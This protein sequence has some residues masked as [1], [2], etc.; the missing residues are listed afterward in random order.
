MNGSEYMYTV[1]EVGVGLSGFAAIVMV[2]RRREGSSLS[3]LDRLM[4][5]TLIER[6]LMAAFLSLLPV[7]LFGLGLSEPL[8]WAVSSGTFVIYGIWIEYRAIR[9]RRY[10]IDKMMSMSLY[11]GL[12]GIGVAVIIV[13]LMHALGVGMQ[14]SAWWY[15][16]GVTW[17]LV[18]AGYRFFF[19][20]REWIHGQ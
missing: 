13:Q 19:I 6:G 18:T 17:L 20:L 3:S 1:A 7:L 5:A 2:M 4:V 11:L 15:M 14:Q 10:I 16:I 9:N 12:I 8:L